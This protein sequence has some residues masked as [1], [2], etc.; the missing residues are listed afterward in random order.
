[1]TL[2]KRGDVSSNWNLSF[3]SATMYYI[4]CPV[5]FVLTLT[6][7]VYHNE[8]LHDGIS[9][10]YST[11]VKH[12]PIILFFTVEMQPFSKIF[13]IPRAFTGG[14]LRVGKFDV[15]AS[16]KIFSVNISSMDCGS[17]I[18][19]AHIP[20]HETTV[21]ETKLHV[22]RII[23]IAHNLTEANIEQNVFKILRM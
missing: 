9:L 14:N 16:N 17:Q 4:F 13:L 7:S 1:M 18:V 19:L 20:S 5:I 8:M 21:I 2:F 3:S 22:Y 11:S 15:S 12:V 10:V 6:N 23:S